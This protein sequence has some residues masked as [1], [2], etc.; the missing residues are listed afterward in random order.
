MWRFLNSADGQKLLDSL[1][2]SNFIGLC[3]YDAGARSFY[4]TKP[5]KKLENLKGLKFRSMQNKQTMEMM[6]SL[7]EKPSPMLYG[8]VLNAL[9]N[10]TI[11]GAE[12]NFPS[13]ESSKH[14]Q[15]AKYFLLDQ[16]QR[17]PEV[18]MASKKVW[19]KFSP[20]DQSLIRQAAVDSVKKQRE[21]WDVKEKESEITVRKS[22][23]TI[24]EV[25][26][27]KP[28]QNSVKPMIESY[29]IDFGD[30]LKAIDKARTAKK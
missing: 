11:D 2:A 15:V 7:G 30:I 5:I 1:S 4:S 18:L 22:G 27:L 20:A 16:H 8:E 17:V 28:F 24:T 3:Y 9:K 10:G 19:D 26:D 6:S 21:L 25:K 23:C 13:Y 29:K 14:Y 12:N